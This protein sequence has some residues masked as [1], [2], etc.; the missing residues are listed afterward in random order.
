MS[1]RDRIKNGALVTTAQ[2]PETGSVPRLRTAIAGAAV[3]KPTGRAIAA[4]DKISSPATVRSPRNWGIIADATSSR[5]NTWETEAQPA[6]RKLFNTLAARGNHS[7]MRL[8]YF[9]GDEEPADSG[10]RG[11]P[12]KIAAIMSEVS[13]YAGLTQFIKSFRPFLEDGKASAIAMV[14]DCFEESEEEMLSLAREMADRKIKVFAF[15]EGDNP[16][17]EE[18]YRKIA[19][20]TGGSFAAFGG[21]MPLEDLFE[22]AALLESGGES[23]LARLR[24]QNAAR[25][26]LIGCS[27]G[28]K[29]A[30]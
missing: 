22:G 25:Q 21:D 30:P 18:I 6:M 16:T 14:G 2:K 7:E 11:S 24:N 23:A 13:C 4:L 5:K 17:A 27:S 29:A 12:D 10:W 1:L 15:L 20:I 3:A 8:V 9:R 28:P 26:L 19:E